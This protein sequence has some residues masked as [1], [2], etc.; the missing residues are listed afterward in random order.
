MTKKTFIDILKIT[1]QYHQKYW[2]IPI[3]VIFEAANDFQS[4]IHDNKD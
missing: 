2:G 4:H 1:K 3:I